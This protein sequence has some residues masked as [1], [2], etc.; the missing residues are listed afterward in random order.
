M[1][2]SLVVSC[3]GVRLLSFFL[4]HCLTLTLSG[5]FLFSLPLSA[6]DI[7][8]QVKLDHKACGWV[9]IDSE[10]GYDKRTFQLA[11]T[12]EDKYRINRV[13]D[14]SSALSRPV[15]YLWLS[16]A[17]KNRQRP[18]TRLTVEVTTTSSM[19]ANNK[20]RYRAK[21]P[22]N[23]VVHSEMLR[24]YPEHLTLTQQ[25]Y[26]NIHELFLAFNPAQGTMFA[27]IIF[28]LSL[29]AAPVHIT[30]TS[31]TPYTLRQKQKYSIH[32]SAI[33]QPSTLTD[34]STVISPPQASSLDIQTPDFAGHCTYLGK[35]LEEI[36]IA[37]GQ[38]HVSFQRFTGQPEREMEEGE[39]TRVSHDSSVHSAPRIHS[40]DSGYH[41]FPVAGTNADQKFT[42]GYYSLPHSINY[43]TSQRTPDIRTPE[44]VINP[45]NIFSTGQVATLQQRDTS[46][47]FPP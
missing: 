3:R 2:L 36:N 39:S 25:R 15:I 19:E 17:S 9:Y 37:A 46:L 12:L 30:I 10:T 38:Y 40:L 23:K 22:A 1:E 45:V 4:P 31:T 18:S 42:R 34:T 8:F 5:L 20:T 35:D 24:Q 21:S 43:L 28:D 14:S 7:A 27:G 47:P 26:P 41:S 32:W 13:P 6:G 16:G 11:T 44:E 29:Y 33:A